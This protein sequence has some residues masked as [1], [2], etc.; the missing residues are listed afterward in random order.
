MAVW[1]WEK[2]SWSTWDQFVIESPSH[3]SFQSG[4]QLCGLLPWIW[5]LQVSA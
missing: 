1:A 4:E 2:Q 3:Q 5:L